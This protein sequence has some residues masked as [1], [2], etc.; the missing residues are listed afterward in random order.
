MPLAGEGRVRGIISIF[1]HLPFA[2]GGILF[3]DKYQ[4]RLASREGEG[5]FHEKEAK[6]NP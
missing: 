3:T 6:N 5:E 1:S 2:K 4:G